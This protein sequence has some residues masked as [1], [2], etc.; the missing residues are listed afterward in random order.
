[1]NDEL[2]I[3]IQVFHCD[4]RLCLPIKSVGTC[5]MCGYSGPGPFHFCPK[6]PRESYCEKHRP[7]FDEKMREAASS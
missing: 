3:E 7:I 4:C 6:A 1:M 5:S 2:E